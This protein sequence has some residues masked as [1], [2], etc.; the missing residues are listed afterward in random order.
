M[1]GST[2][3]FNVI[4]AR[5]YLGLDSGELTRTFKPETRRVL[6]PQ[7]IQPTLKSAAI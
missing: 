3:Q 4:L 5:H 7:A 2:L 6:A 1:P